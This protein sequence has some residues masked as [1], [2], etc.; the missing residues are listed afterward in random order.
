MTPAVDKL[1]GRGLS[2]TACC[3]SL[4]K[5]K[6]VMQYWPQKDYIPGNTNKSEHFNYKGEWAN[7]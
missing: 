5:K 1:N 2:N 7:A 3:E 4:P 6:K